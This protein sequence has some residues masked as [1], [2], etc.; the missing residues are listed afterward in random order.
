MKVENQANRPTRA[1]GDFEATLSARR[2]DKR[3]DDAA[4]AVQ[5]QVDAETVGLFRKYGLPLPDRLRKTT[6]RD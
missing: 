5:W 2:Y 3:L 4:G 6:W 1:S